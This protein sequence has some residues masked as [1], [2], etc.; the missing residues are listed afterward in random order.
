M[1]IG[2]NGSDGSNE[3]LDV[4][5]DSET[6][7]MISDYGSLSYGAIASLVKTR[8]MVCGGFIS[9]EPG[10]ECFVYDPDVS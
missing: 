3:L 7:P 5:D 2:G 10:D 4:E 9:F 8:I 1:A 6:C